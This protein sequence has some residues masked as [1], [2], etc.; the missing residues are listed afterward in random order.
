M[1]HPRQPD[2]R[3]Y[4][5]VVTA[6]VL[7]L[8]VLLPGGLAYS[9]YRYLDPAS[10][11]ALTVS[12]PAAGPEPEEEPGPSGQARPPDRR[13]HADQ[14]GD[15]NFRMGDVAFQARKVGGWT[16][17]SCAP[18]DRRGLL[19][20]S[21]C[22]R[23]VQLAYRAYGGH[24]TA[25]QMIMAFPG[26]K[27]AQAALKRLTGASGAVKWRRDTM[28]DT[29]AY[30][31]QRLTRTRSYVLLTVVTADKT[32]RARAARFHRYLHADHAASFLFRDSAASG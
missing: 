16:Y 13:I 32:A 15:W 2:V 17:A 29:Y 21:G 19:A 30:G 22:E 11:P 12:W 6:L 7:I 28:L 18:V 25:I 4:P 9:L 8:V 20:A 1:A 31:K 27:A 23:V 24:L 26:E 3:E 10:A 14:Y 5:G